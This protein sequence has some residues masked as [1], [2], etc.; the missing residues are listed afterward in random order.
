M[1]NE[2]PIGSGISGAAGGEC[3]AQEVCG[4]SGKL[5]HEGAVFVVAER[6]EVDRDTNASSALRRAAGERDAQGEKLIDDDGHQQRRHRAA[7]ADAVEDQ[8]GRSRMQPIFPAIGDQIIQREK[9]A[10]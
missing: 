3:Q 6:Q 2:M 7:G 9:I 8:A 10:A 1:K 4:T 5:P